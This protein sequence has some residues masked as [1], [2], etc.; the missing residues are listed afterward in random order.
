MSR[1]GRPPAERPPSWLRRV[2]QRSA[3]SWTSWRRTW[4]E[5][6]LARKRR[7]V[8]RLLLPLMLPVAEAMRR[9]EARQAET[10]ALVEQLALVQHPL[11][12]SPVQ[13]ELMHREVTGLLLELLQATQP[14]PVDQLSDLLSG[15]PLPTPT[16]P[17][18]ES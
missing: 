16:S 6:R 14:D 11:P 13:A 1:Q 2:T 5:R 10:R 12:V 4:T 7:Q 8:E 15:Q 3:S 18:S 17:S 9:L